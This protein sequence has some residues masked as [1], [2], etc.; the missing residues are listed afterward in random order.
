MAKIKTAAER[1]LERAKK[2][3]KLVPV[4]CETCGETWECRKYDMQ[5]WIESGVMPAD[6]AAQ[7]VEAYKSASGAAI[8]EAELVASLDEQ[9]LMRSIEFTS[10]VVRM[11]A[12]NPSISEHADPASNVLGYEQVMKCCYATLRDFQI[13]GGGK[14]GN[15]ETFH[16][17]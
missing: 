7:V 2:V 15:L 3:E 10:K 5:F 8:S 17:E 4:T 11:T 6:L 12:V 9:G 1:Y 14:A 13:K 16:K